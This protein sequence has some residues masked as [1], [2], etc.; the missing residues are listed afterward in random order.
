VSIHELGLQM[1]ITVN[2]GQ[3]DLPNRQPARLCPPIG[4]VLFEEKNTALHL[5]QLCSNSRMKMPVDFT[6]SGSLYCAPQF[7]LDNLLSMYN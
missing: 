3:C 7:C 5:G 1:R 2:R 6:Q 4:A